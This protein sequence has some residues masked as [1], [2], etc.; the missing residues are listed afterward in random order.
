MSR[1]W[2]KIRL[3][4]AAQSAKGLWIEGLRNPP[5]CLSAPLREEIGDKNWY[6]LSK[7]FSDRQ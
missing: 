3:E 2:L 6:Q 7:R 4:A 1:L 5:L